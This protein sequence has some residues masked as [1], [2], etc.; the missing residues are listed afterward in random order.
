MLDLL[1][2]ETG[3]DCTT[4]QIA[5][6][7]VNDCVTPPLLRSTHAIWQQV[8]SWALKPGD[9][10]VVLTNGLVSERWAKQLGACGLRIEVMPS[11][12]GEDVSAKDLARRLGRD[13]T[14]EVRAVFVREVEPS[15]GVASGLTAV[16]RAMNESFHDALL[17]VDATGHASTLPMQM[18]RHGV[19]IAVLEQDGAL[20]MAIAPHLRSARLASDYASLG[21]L[22]AHSEPVVG[23]EQVNESHDWIVAALRDALAAVDLGLVA[24]HPRLAAR[25]VTAIRLSEAIDG[26]A[27]VRDAISVGAVR[28]EAFHDPARGQILSLFHPVGT[29]LRDCVA[30]IEFLEEALFGAGAGVPPAAG[31]AAVRHHLG[32]GRVR[33]C[34]PFDMAAE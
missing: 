29:S 26:V 19:D 27:V 18:R 14:D 20:A 30:V 33:A 13:L 15:T 31:V 34:T 6:Q 12:F 8:V 17:I 1:P 28:L 2:C 11:A 21:L 32:M 25:G 24:R 23:P 10:V 22:F 9:R 4:M 3:L 7:R 16:R 5:D